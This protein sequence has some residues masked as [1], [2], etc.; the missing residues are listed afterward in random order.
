M[1][2]PHSRIF[3][4]VVCAFT[5]I[6]VHIYMTP[7]PKTTI[8]GSHKELLLAGIEPATCCPAA[9]YP[10][11][12]QPCS[13][14]FYGVEFF[15]GVEPCCGT[16][17]AAPITLLFN[18]LNTRFPS[19]L[20]IPNPQ[21]ACNALVTPLVFRVSM[22]GGDCLPSADHS[23]CLQAY[24]MELSGF[25]LCRRCVYKHTSSHTH[26]IQT[27]NNN[28]WITQRVAPC[29]NRSRYTLHGSQLPSHRAN[30]AFKRNRL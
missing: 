27:R 21:R 1:T 20:E 4:W 17:C 19:N 25:F 23:A 28:L 7:R 15:A 9:G 16:K 11:T 3:S 30:R 6:Q 10:A 2:L 26:D 18:L 29:G 22:G 24:I 13:R 14:N 5:N 8:C 12:R